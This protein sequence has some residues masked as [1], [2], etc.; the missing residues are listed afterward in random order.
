MSENRTCSVAQAYRQCPSFTMVLWKSAECSLEMLLCH[1]MS[2][3]LEC[4]CWREHSEVGGAEASPQ[5]FGGDKKAT[6][7]S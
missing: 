2:Q 4:G 6:V 5:K 3:T 1:I 7:I